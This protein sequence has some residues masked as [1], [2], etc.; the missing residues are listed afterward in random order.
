MRIEVPK[1][2]YRGKLREVNDSVIAEHRA[3]GGQLVTAF[4]GAP[5]LLLNHRGARTGR[6]YTSPL[7]YSRDGDDYVIIASL[8]GA[9]QNPHWF[10]NLVAYPDVTIE[11]GGEEIA[12]RARVTEGQERDRL[13]R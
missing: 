8:G 5:I 3:T 6:P 10:H 1:E 13:Y 7:A 4:A 9:P 12:V 11:V 2:M